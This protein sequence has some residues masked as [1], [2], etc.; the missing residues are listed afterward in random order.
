MRFHNLHPAHGHDHPSAA[1]TEQRNRYAGTISFVEE[2]THTAPGGDPAF[3]SQDMCASYTASRPTERTAVLCMPGSFGGGTWLVAKKGVGRT[4]VVSRHPFKRRLRP[5]L[6][7]VDPERQDKQD[8]RTPDYLNHLRAY[9]S[10]HLWHMRFLDVGVW[11]LGH[12]L[13]CGRD[14]DVRLDVDKLS[15]RRVE[16]EAVH[17]RPVERKHQLRRGPVHAVPGN[18]HAGR[19]CALVSEFRD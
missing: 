14:F 1:E 11:M 13:G 7:I 2:R 16:R 17:P 3:E 15:Q 6:P 5:D 9:S 12:H 18:L 8:A 4:H 19:G 10:L